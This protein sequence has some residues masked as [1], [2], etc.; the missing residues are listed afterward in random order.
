MGTYKLAQTLQSERSSYLVP[1]ENKIT[2]VELR[3]QKQYFSFAWRELGN[4][5]AG[6]ARASH[7]WVLS[8]SLGITHYS[9]RRM[10]TLQRA[11]SS[12]TQCLTMSGS[13]NCAQI[14][15]WLQVLATIAITTASATAHP[16]P[17]SRP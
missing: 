11:L 7:S 16:N 10:T 6:C 17:N 9:R 4:S 14:L 3:T 13:T 2:W 5:P 8:C 1:L 12:Y 15:K